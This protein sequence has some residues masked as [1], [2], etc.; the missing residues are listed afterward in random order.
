MEGWPDIMNSYRIY[1]DYYGF[2]FIAFNLVVSY[3][4]LNLFIG[5][6][7]K[8]FN[9]AFKR[10]QKIA[11][12]D[13]KAP[14]YYDFLNQILDE[15]S[16]YIIWNKPMK[17]TIKYY[18]REFVDNEIF[19]YTMMT[20]ILLNMILM[21][22]SF[23]GSP[24]NLSNLLKILN[25]FFTIIFIIECLLKLFAYGIKPYF[26]I[27]WNKFDFFVVVVSLIDWI[28]NSVDG[29]DASFLK[30]F[31]IIRVLKVLTVSRV[32]R[33]IKALKGLEKLI[34]TLQ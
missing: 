27:S 29:I 10:E 22:I 31:Q 6:M 23:D 16:D 26:H 15:K 25:Y 21:V 33:L 1:N 24:S 9:E 32:I 14:K 19:Q 4:F 20:I 5:I 7:L 11:K 13:K 8:Y 2:Y 30:T 3:F 17:G 12:D 34:Q 28:V 18:L